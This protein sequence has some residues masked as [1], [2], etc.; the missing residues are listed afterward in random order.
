MKALQAEDNVS[1]TKNRMTSIIML[2]TLVGYYNNHNAMNKRIESR[3]REATIQIMII[4]YILPVYTYSTGVHILMG[5]GG[6]RGK[7]SRI[8]FVQ[9][10]K[11]QQIENNSDL[12][13]NLL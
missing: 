6:V 8:T 4:T 2:H 1:L 9:K 5:G 13:F 3:Y 11:H 7:K 10:K 12:M